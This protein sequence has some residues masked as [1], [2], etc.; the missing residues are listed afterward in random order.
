MAVSGLAAQIIQWVAFGI[1]VPFVVLRLYAR[2]RALRLGL[3]DLL[4]VLTLAMF[5]THL[6]LNTELARHGLFDNDLSYVHGWTTAFPDKGVRTYLMKISYAGYIPYL[7]ELWGV[8]FSL[9]ALY[10]TLITVQ[11]PK[12][13]IALHCITAYTVVTIIISLIIYL[14]WCVPITMNWSVDPED[15]KKCTAGQVPYLVPVGFHMSSDFALYLLP[16]ILLKSLSMRLPRRQFAGVLGLFGLGAICICISIGRIIAGKQEAKVTTVVVWTALEMAA[17]VIVICLP[18]LKVLLPKRRSHQGSIRLSSAQGDSSG[19]AAVKDEETFG[20]WFTNKT[21][22]VKSRTLSRASDILYSHSSVIEEGTTLEMEAQQR[23]RE[24]QQ[25]QQSQPQRRHSQASQNRRSGR[26]SH[27]SQSRFLRRLSLSREHSIR[28][29]DAAHIPSSPTRIPS[30]PDRR[31]HSRD[32]VTYPPSEF[33]VEE[34][35]RQN[36]GNV[37]ES[38][39]ALRDDILRSISFAY[40]EQVYKHEHHTHPPGKT[41]G[42]G[43]NWR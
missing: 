37:Q 41:T 1:T 11:L 32:A 25:Q 33:K 34:S 4:V 42:S 14:F 21:N 38:V 39:N 9:I 35:L 15:R 8:K 22:T 29:P 2:H 7:L 5:L 40:D 36:N 3:S 27:A 28:E 16:F 30:S 24:S 10:Y 6:I 31:R 19:A 17:G 12:L 13:R 43:S 23:H 20:S 18:A 26:S